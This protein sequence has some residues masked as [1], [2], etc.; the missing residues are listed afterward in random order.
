MHVTVSRMISAGAFTA[1]VAGALTLGYVKGAAAQPT[2]PTILSG[3]DIR[4]QVSPI[5]QSSAD[6]SVEGVLMVRING[7]WVTAKVQDH[8]IPRRGVKPLE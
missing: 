3:D 8:L 4:F 6:G 1:V 7:K 2:S 5:P